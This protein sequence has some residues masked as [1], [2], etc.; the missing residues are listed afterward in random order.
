MCLLLCFRPTFSCFES[1]YASIYVCVF[2]E[3]DVYVSV[4]EMKG[5]VCFCV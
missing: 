1:V 2:I 5:C 4:F 3:R